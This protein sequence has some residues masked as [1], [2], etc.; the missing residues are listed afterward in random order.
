MLGYRKDPRGTRRR[1]AG[2]A[3][4]L[5]PALRHESAKMPYAEGLG[6]SLDAVW[7]MTPMTLDLKRD[8]RLVGYERMVWSS[9]DRSYYDRSW[10]SVVTEPYADRA[11]VLHITE[12][13]M[14][15]ILNAHPFVCLGGPGALAQLR[16]YGFETFEPALDERYDLE[17]EPRARMRLF[18]DELLRLG[19]LSHADLRAMCLEL[20]PRCEHNVMHFWTGARERLGQAFRTE[21]LDQL[22]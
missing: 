8:F 20:W 2:E 1:G 12:K 16:A 19:G 9:Q 11:Q 17:P 4:E 3:V 13:I 14:K 6:P 21:V 15:P 5:P 10:F 22:L 18:L 7:R